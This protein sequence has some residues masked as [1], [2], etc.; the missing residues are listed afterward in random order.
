M[1]NI[2]A[3]SITVINTEVSCIIRV[4]R[5]QQHIPLWEKFAGRYEFKPR[6]AL[7][8]T[9]GVW[10]YVNLADG[11]TGLAL[12]PD[13]C[14]SNTAAQCLEPQWLG[15]LRGVP[16]DFLNIVSDKQALNGEGELYLAREKMRWAMWFHH[17]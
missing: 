7:A 4:Y 3:C 8:Y 16:K 10:G 2:V 5:V 9:K 12:L 17:S 6:N 15:L 13:G 1:P 11:S 14:N